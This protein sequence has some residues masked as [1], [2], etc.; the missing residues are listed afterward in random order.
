MKGMFYGCVAL[1]A[2][3][4]GWNVASVSSMSNM[5]FGC[6]S[7]NSNLSAWNTSSVKDMRGMFYNADS[8]SSNMGSW[9]LSALDAADR[10]DDL[11]IYAT[12]LKTADYDATLIAWNANKASFRNDL[13]PN[14]GGSKYTAGGAAASARAALVAYGWTITDGGTA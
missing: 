1:N 2:N 12:G 14:F 13:R 9:N 10:V 5:F 6:T 3:V 4:S 11:M 7:F 8:Y